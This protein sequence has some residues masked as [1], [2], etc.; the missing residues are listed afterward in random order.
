MLETE[1]EQKR[2]VISGSTFAIVASRVGFTS[3]SLVAGNLSK[4]KK[5][6]FGKPPHSIIIPG[7]L[8]FTESDAL[9]VLADCL[10]KPESNS[11]SIKNQL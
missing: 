3:Q 6:D 2:K 11:D 9:K 5:Y 4:L 8:H 10:D 7:R 1:N